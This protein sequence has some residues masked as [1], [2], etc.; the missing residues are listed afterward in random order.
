MLWGL[1]V[2]QATLTV[3]IFIV[4]IMLGRGDHDDSR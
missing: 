4:A 2:A 3:A 1:V